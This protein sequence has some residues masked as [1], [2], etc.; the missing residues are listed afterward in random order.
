MGPNRKG[1]L[2]VLLAIRPDAFSEWSLRNR[3]KEIAEED[4]PKTI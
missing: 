3:F 1:G 4:T 2:R